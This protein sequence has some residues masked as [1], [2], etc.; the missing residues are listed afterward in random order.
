M[1]FGLLEI[2]ILNCTMGDVMLSVIPINVERKKI[3]CKYILNN[4]KQKLLLSELADELSISNRNCSRIIRDQFGTTFPR[5][6]NAVRLY[7]TIEYYK[8][9]EGGIGESSIK[10]GFPDRQTFLRW[11]NHWVGLPINGKKISVKRI[12]NKL[13]EEYRKIIENVLLC[14]KET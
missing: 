11:W 9:H 8:N 3:I 6:L 7:H 13:S 5:L 12:H 4:H 2:I 14:L 1:R 10:C